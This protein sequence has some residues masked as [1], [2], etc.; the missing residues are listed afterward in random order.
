[1]QFLGPILASDAITAGC[2]S[3]GEGRKLTVAT[4]MGWTSSGGSA[5][6]VIVLDPQDRI[7]AIRPI[8]WAIKVHGLDDGQSSLKRLLGVALPDAIRLCDSLAAARSTEQVWGM[9]G[10]ALRRLADQ[11]AILQRG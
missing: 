11:H 10:G 3:G 9:L 1:L 7:I 5:E 4:A 2:I 8:S 6:C